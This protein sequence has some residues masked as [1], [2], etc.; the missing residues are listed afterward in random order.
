MRQDLFFSLTV[1]PFLRCKVIVDTSLETSI[2]AFDTKHV[3]SS[4]LSSKSLYNRVGK[5]P[6]SLISVSFS[7]TTSTSRYGRRQQFKLVLM[8]HAT[9]LAI[10]VYYSV[11]HRLV[12][13]RFSAGRGWLSGGCCGVVLFS[14]QW[15]WRVR[16]L[17]HCGGS[18]TRNRCSL[19]EDDLLSFFHVTTA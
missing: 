10:F 17:C 6:I 7:I 4:G 18:G 5:P 2:Y 15:M 16:G 12:E 9:N 3:A 1:N 19:A 11:H 14:F 13:Q 8:N